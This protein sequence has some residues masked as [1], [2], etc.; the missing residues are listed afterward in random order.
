V[1]V[2]WSVEPDGLRVMASVPAGCRAQ[3]VA[4]DGTATP[5]TD[6]LTARWQIGN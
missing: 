2:W 1:Q 4:P 3:A 6:T 5:F